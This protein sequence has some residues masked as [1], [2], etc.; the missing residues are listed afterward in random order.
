MANESKSQPTF[1]TADIHSCLEYFLENTLQMTSEDITHIKRCIYYNGWRITR[2][3]EWLSDANKKQWRLNE[4]VNVKQIV[5][6]KVK[7]FSF[8]R[9]V[10]CQI[11][12]SFLKIND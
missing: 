8:F 1:L 10:S 7:Y 12:N 9:F 5:S 2:I 6:F 11:S 4:I 3:N